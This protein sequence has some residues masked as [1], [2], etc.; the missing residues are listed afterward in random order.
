[1]ETNLI[2]DGFLGSWERWIFA[3]QNYVGFLHLGVKGYGFEHSEFMLLGGY[4]NFYIL[5]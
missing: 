3:W 5:P 4:L 2:E 1:M